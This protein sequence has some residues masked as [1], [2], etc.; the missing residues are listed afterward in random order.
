MAT[1]SDEKYRNGKK[2]IEF[3]KKA[4][5][6]KPKDASIFDTLAAAYA[7]AEKFE[8]A[9]KTQEKAIEMLKEKDKDKYLSEL[10]ERLNFYKANKPW[11]EKPKSGK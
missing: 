2:A 3:V 9:V 6:L 7:E 4:I 8:D 10:T 1:C 11:R 5:E